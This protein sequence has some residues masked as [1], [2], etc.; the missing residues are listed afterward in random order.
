MSSQWKREEKHSSWDKKL[1]WITDWESTQIPQWNGIYYNLFRWLW[2]AF[3]RT[4][5][6]FRSEKCNHIQ[7][8]GN[9]FHLICRCCDKPSR[10]PC[11]WKHH[12]PPWLW[13]CSSCTSS[14]PAGWCMASCTLN[15]ATAPKVTNASC[16]FW[17][18]T[19]NYRFIQSSGCFWLLWA[20]VQMFLISG[21]LCP[22]EYLHCS[23][24]QRR[25]RTHPDPQRRPIWCEQQAWEVWLFIISNYCE[26]ETVFKVNIQLTSKFDAC[27]YLFTP[28]ISEFCL[29]S[30]RVVNVSLP[31]KTRNNGT[32]YAMIFVHQAGVNPWQD[33]RKVHSVAHLTTY[34]VPKPP[35]ISLISRED[36]TMV[37]LILRRTVY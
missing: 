7:Q 17:L 22:V 18:G 34:M 15:L 8:F 32:L 9:H 36:Q 31:K 35:E 6:L 1:S 26:I 2:T 27:Y 24:A 37:V 28:V 5:L 11:S 3:S 19:L 29:C 25:G 10:A 12:S 33:Q 13:G 30:S 16:P 23:A 14:T 21:S 4:G 20:R